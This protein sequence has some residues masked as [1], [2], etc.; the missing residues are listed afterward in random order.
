[1][2]F[3]CW[4]LQ[5]LALMILLRNSFDGF[6]IEEQRKALLELKQVGT[7]DGYKIHCLNILNTFPEPAEHQALAIS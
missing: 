4:I 2:E 5:S 6:F 7:F 1:M 3:L